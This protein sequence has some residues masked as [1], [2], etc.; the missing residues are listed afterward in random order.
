MST[1]SVTDYTYLCHA[2]HE[3]TK[4]V[5]QSRHGCVAV[6]NGRIVGRGYNS[7]RTQSCDGFINNTCSCHAEMAALRDLWHTSVGSKSYG[8]YSKQIKGAGE[9]KDF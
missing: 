8:N 4:S 9:R 2:A 7:H 1:L 3:S 5:L 6:S